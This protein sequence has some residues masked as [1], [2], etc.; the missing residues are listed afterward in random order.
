MNVRVQKKCMFYDI[1]MLHEGINL[2]G[3]CMTDGELRHQ[4]V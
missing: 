3:Q 1:D 4:A 2:D